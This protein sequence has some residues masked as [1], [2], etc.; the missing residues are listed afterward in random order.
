MDAVRKASVA[1]VDH[2]PST[3]G[4]DPLPD[5]DAAGLS[6][7]PQA[8]GARA[9]EGTVPPSEQPDAPE[10]DPPTLHAL[11]TP[12]GAHARPQTGGGQRPL[13]LAVRTAAA[14][15]PE[16]RAALRRDATPDEIRQAIAELG[17]TEAIALYGLLLTSPYLIDHG[18]EGDARETAQ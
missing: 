16:E 17:R 15:S 8:V 3:Y 11:P 12:P 13:L 4:R 7:Q 5:E 10:Q 14:V 2:I 1:G 9:D 6:P 18:L